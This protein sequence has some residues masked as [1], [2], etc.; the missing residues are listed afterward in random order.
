M[1]QPGLYVFAKGVVTVKLVDLDLQWRRDRHASRWRRL[2][3]WIV[4][5]LVVSSLVSN[6]ATWFWTPA[7]NAQ[8][9]VD[10]AAEGEMP[11]GDDA[12][13]KKPAKAAA[14]PAPSG[15]DSAALDAA[16]ESYLVW[17]HNAS[18]PFGY[19]IG[20]E[21]IILVALVISGILQF[22]RDVFIPPD[23]VT[24]FEQKL[25]AKDFQ[26]AYDSAKRDDSF[27]ARLLAAGIAKLGRGYDEVA[28]G[29]QEAGE[30][31]NLALDHRLSYI[32]LIGTTAPM[33]GLLG[34]V[35]G[36][37]MAF[38]RIATSAVSPKPSELAKGITLALVTTLEGLMVAIPAIIAFGLLKNR[39]TRLVWDAGLVADGLLSRVAKRPAGSAGGTASPAAPAAPER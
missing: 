17:L 36:M 4:L 31:E 38:D 20:I 14:E 16:S 30:D 34:T 21:S 5:G 33:F 29:M 13:A 24:E 7:V 1:D 6:N 25:T 22:R 8:E 32:S 37:V 11:A 12:P 27:V 3:R 2:A 9:P 15:N 23:F 39:Q 10:N 28:A 35:Q 26:G 18:G 19:C